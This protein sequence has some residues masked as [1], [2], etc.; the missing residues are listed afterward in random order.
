M[1]EPETEDS[2]YEAL[3]EHIPNTTTPEKGPVIEGTPKLQET[4]RALLLDNVDRLQKEVNKKQ[5]V[6]PPMKLNVDEKR[7][8]R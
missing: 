1:G 3:Q 6:V 8:M 7:W 2:I 5:A 4:L